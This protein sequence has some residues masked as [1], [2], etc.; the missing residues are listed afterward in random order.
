MGR[1][2]IR[3]T[4]GQDI[5]S[6]MRAHHGLGVRRFGR[7]APMATAQHLSAGDQDRIS[8]AHGLSSLTVL[9]ILMQIL[10]VMP[11]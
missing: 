5:A 3:L 10:K 4:R 9:G 1:A 11:E 2:A 8:D 6:E 7:A